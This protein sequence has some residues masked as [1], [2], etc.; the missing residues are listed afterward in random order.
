MNSS[1]LLAQIVAIDETKAKG[2]LWDAFQLIA[3]ILI[4]ALVILLFFT[5]TRRRRRRRRH[6]PEILKNSEE[7]RRR[8]DQAIETGEPI[9]R[10][11]RK[12][13]PGH[14]EFLPNPSISESGGLP[15]R[16]EENSAS[17][18]GS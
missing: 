4:L 17:K 13:R 15:P 18:P 7:R 10:R 6:T 14:T 3:I 16:R 5:V 2:T 9:K 12:R 8:I 1:M 11:R